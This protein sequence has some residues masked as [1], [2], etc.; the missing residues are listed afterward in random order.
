MKMYL[1]QLFSALEY[2][3]NQESMPAFDRRLENGEFIYTCSIYLDLPNKIEVE[4]QD[5]S[6]K[7]LIML[8]EKELRKKWNLKLGNL[9]N[10]S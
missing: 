7:K 9:N 2:A 10:D 1:H 6:L 3:I 4:L 5:K 8:V